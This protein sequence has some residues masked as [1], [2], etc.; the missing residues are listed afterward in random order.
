M[1]KLTSFVRQYAQQKISRF[2]MPGHK[3]NC[4]FLRE[5]G[6]PYDITEIQGA[7]VLFSPSGLLKELEE[8]YSRLYGSTTVLSAG[9]STLCIQAMLAVAKR[10][11]GGILAARNIHLAF[12][13]SCVL[14]DLSPQW[15]FTQPDSQTGLALPPTPEQVARALDR[16]K[17]IRTFYLTSP[18]YMG[19]I[20]D[21][22][23]IAQVCRDRDVLLLV[24]AAHGAHLRFLREDAHPIS[25]GA[26]L[27]CT[28]SHKTLPALTGAALLHARELPADVLKEQMALFGSTSPSYLILQSLDLCADYLESHGR[29]DFAG[30]EEQ[31]EYC[32]QIV[33]QAALQPLRPSDPTKL[34]LDAHAVGWTGEELGERFRS[35]RME[36]EYASSRHLVLMLS[37]FNTAT[38]YARLEAATNILEKRPP[39]LEKESIHIPETVLSPR[40]AVLSPSVSLPVEEA[41]GKICAE[42][43]ITCPPGIPVVAAGER[44]DGELIRRLK[45]SRILSIK[46]VQ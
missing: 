41:Q 4:S 30:L 32:A 23:G 8:T 31:W 5:L 33:S 35:F 21:I 36:P 45:K 28:S 17:N 10:R 43:K 44:L 14:L 24:D 40:Q 27:C 1:A 9:G 18:D 42:N 6:G 22:R 19:Q 29:E 20:A 11:G 3:G 38:D 13:N 25:L 34:T 12:L 26:D 15:L 16:D 39:I 7:D 37:P 46:V 2:H